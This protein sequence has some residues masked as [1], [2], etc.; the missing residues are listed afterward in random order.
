[1]A[2]I[3]KYKKDFGIGGE[4]YRPLEGKAVFW[5]VTEGTIR[6]NW[7]QFNRR[8]FFRLGYQ[9]EEKMRRFRSSS[10]NIHGGFVASLILIPVSLSI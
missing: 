3:E 7:K 6:Y 9:Q 1:M 4:S 10:I 2:V 8:N 5:F